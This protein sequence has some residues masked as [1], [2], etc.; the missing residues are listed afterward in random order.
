MPNLAYQSPD[1]Y[2]FSQLVDAAR[3]LR[4][5]MVE[6]QWSLGVCLAWRMFVG[7]IGGR[8]NGAESGGEFWGLVVLLFA[9]LILM[10]MIDFCILAMGTVLAPTVVL[11]I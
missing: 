8:G 4:S 10:Y 2:F 9:Q 1:M 11:Y 3:K 5:F 7:K 6:G